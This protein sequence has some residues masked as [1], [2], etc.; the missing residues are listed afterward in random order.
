MTPRQRWAAAALVLLAFGFTASWGGSW[1]AKA[2]ELEAQL[3][4]AR[5]REAACSESVQ[6]LHDA[7]AQSEAAAQKA[8]AAAQKDAAAHA[9]RA[10]ALLR[11][12]AAVPGDDC[13]SARARAR[14][15]LEGRR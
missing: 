4:A 2:G 6:R 13:A 5:V 8:L 14:A 15:W 7:A 1:K 10:D 3:E 11:Q 9:K 12:G